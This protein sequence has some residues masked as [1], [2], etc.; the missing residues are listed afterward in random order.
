MPSSRNLEA[1]AIDAQDLVKS[2]GPL[3][4]V[5]GVSLQLKAGRSLALLGPNGAG[6]DHPGRNAGRPATARP[7]Q[8]PSLRPKLAGGR[9]LGP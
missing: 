4:A 9:V 1:L 6:K 5:A 3:T 7:G 2:F 8:H